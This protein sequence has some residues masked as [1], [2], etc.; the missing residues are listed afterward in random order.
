VG[1][2]EYTCNP[3]GEMGKR[4]ES[5]RLNGKPLEAGRKYKVA[6]WA[7]VSE[8]ARDANLPPVWELVEK[9][10]VA[11]GGKVAARQPNLPTLTGALPN[12]GFA[13]A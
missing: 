4:I 6:G 7:P 5:M 13:R 3:L 12:P 9:W 1:G 2:L 10:L 11:R 8:E